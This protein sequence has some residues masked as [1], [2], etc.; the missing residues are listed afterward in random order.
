MASAITPAPIHVHLQGE[1][2]LYG[3]LRFTHKSAEEVF[4]AW[5]TARPSFLQGLTGAVRLQTL[6]REFYRI[7]EHLPRN[8]VDELASIVD[9]RGKAKMIHVANGTHDQGHE[10]CLNSTE[11]N[12]NSFPNGADTAKPNFGG[13]L[14]SYQL[15]KLCF[16]QHVV[17]RRS[18]LIQQY[19]LFRPRL[20]F[21]GLVGPRHHV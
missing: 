11:T 18:V 8:I 12:S 3:K 10:N 17:L 4:I 13:R 6:E 1:R 5:V 14:S 7:E 20:L 16:R 19:N 2:K 15:T 21:C 9:A